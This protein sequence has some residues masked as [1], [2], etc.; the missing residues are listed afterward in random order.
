MD[1]SPGYDWQ[2]AMIHLANVIGVAAALASAIWIADDAE[3]DLSPVLALVPVL[4]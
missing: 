1:W 4:S 3:G 2:A